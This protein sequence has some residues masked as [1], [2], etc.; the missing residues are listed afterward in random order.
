MQPEWNALACLLADLNLEFYLLA[1]FNKVR[2]RNR[3]E[4]YAQTND[5][6]SWADFDDHATELIN[7]RTF[8][9]DS[10]ADVYFDT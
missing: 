2:R 9:N 8:S 3:I 4:N 10:D 6:W 1:K 5:L 7:S